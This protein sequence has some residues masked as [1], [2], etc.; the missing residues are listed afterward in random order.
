MSVA[1]QRGTAVV[2]D[3]RAKEYTLVLMRVSL[4]FVFLGCVATVAGTSTACSTSSGGGSSPDGGTVVIGDAG[5]PFALGVPCTDTVNSVYGD[6]GDVSAQHK[7]A[8]LKCAHD[9]DIPVAMLESLARAGDDAGSLGYSG[10]AFTSGAHVYRVLYRTERGDSNNTPGYSSALVLLPDTPR[11]T[12]LPWSLLPRKPRTGGG[13]RA[14][15]GQRGGRVRSSDFIHQV[16]PLVGLGA[17][18]RRISPATPTWRPEQ[19]TERAYAD[20]ADVGKSTLDGARALRPNP[21]ERRD[22]AGRAG[23]PFAGATRRSPRCRWPIAMGRTASSPPSRCM[24]RCGGRNGPGWRSSSS[25]GTTLSTRAPRAPSASG[26]TTRTASCSTGPG[27]ASTSSRRLSS[28]RQGLRE[29]RLLVG[30]LPRPRRRWHVR[31]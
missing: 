23:G 7:G 22:A 28:R 16:Y 15:G 30:E 4:V 13:V 29:Q 9:Q 8:I 19:S 24:H 27:T 18:L 17:S 25:P 26:T 1:K 10:K 12:Q 20:T 21:T 3:C 14:V 5:S 2:W 6:P 31:Q 11:A